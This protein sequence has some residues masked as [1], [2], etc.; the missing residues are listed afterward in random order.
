MD[1]ARTDHDEQSVGSLG[2][3]FDGFKA[4]ASNGLD[5]FRG[6]FFLIRSAV[7]EGADIGSFG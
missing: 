1:G 7:R 6:L 5:G 3:A 2:D 4:A